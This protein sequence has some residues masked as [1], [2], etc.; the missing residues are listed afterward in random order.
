MFLG[1]PVPC[2]AEKDVLFESDNA[3]HIGGYYYKSNSN[4]YLR[5]EHYTFY[6][7]KN[8]DYDSFT[9]L[10]RFFAVDKKRVFYAHTIAHPMFRVALP[11]FH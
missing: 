4:I 3:T 1:I 5:D 9:V 8:A 10:G 7:V 11:T 6:K 2:V